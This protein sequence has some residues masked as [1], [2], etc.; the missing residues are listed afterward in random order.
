MPIETE[1][2]KGFA[3]RF[4]LKVTASGESEPGNYARWSV[5]AVL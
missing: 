4:D 5:G 3:G 2:L 1:S